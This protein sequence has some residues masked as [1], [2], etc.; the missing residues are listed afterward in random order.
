MNFEKNLKIIPAERRKMI[1]QVL[2]GR[3]FVSSLELCDILCASESTV[4]R[5]LELL[6][7]SGTIERVHGGAVLTRH[8]NIESLYSQSKLTNEAEKRR[9]ADFASSLITQ[10]DVVFMNHGTTTTM[11]AQALANRTD[12]Q[13]ITVISSNLGVICSLFETDINLICLGGVCRK[14]S[15]SITGGITL[16]NI[17]SFV[18]NKC[19]LGVDGIDVKFGG[20]F[21]T[22]KDSEVS[23]EMALNTHGQIYIVADHNKW[24]TVSPFKGIQFSRVNSFITGKELDEQID[25]VF[26]EHGVDLHRI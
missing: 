24:G 19:F 5:D 4:R 6:E 18:A 1:L 21:F 22:E 17:D 26:K 9:I 7:E 10:N 23:K 14:Q 2:Q 11:I 20:T 16:S 12:L 8:L 3:Q 25:L 13:N 15:F